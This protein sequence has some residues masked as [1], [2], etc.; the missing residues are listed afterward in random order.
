MPWQ[1]PLPESWLGQLVGGALGAY[2]ISQ[3]A[4][5][6][7]SDLATQQAQQQDIASNIAARSAQQKYQSTQQAME[8][9]ESGFT[10]NPDGTV[11]QEQGPPLPKPPKNANPDQLATFWQ[12]IASDMSR[13]EWQRAQAQQSATGWGNL[14]YKASQTAV[15]QAKVPDIQ[16]HTNYLNS[17]YQRALGVLQQKDRDRM[18]QIRSQEQA[19]LEKQG[20]S[21]ADAMTRA[22]YVAGQEMQRLVVGDQA[23]AALA[24][25]GQQWRQ[26]DLYYSQAMQNY[27]ASENAARMGASSGFDQAGWEA[28]NPPPQQPASINFSPVMVMPGG[29]APQQPQ[30]A[31]G[32]GGLPQ[33]PQGW[34]WTQQ[35]DGRIG[36][37]DAQGNFRPY[38]GAGGSA[39]SAAPRPTGLPVRQVSAPPRVAAPPSR[40]AI[41]KADQAEYDFMVKSYRAQ[42]KSPYEAD[43]QARQTLRLPQVPQQ[44]VAG[45]FGNF[46]RNAFQEHGKAPAAPPA[47]S[48]AAAMAAIQQMKKRYNLSDQQVQQ[49]QPD[50]WSAAHG[51]A[52]TAVP[53]YP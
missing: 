52:A 8:A 36:I 3:Q 13:P 48:R 39:A 37:V 27:R 17:S 40:Y 25:Y 15:N 35:P 21:A 30:P 51:T 31:P 7:K 24:Q 38:T 19:A 11:A 5:Q 43:Q 49:A 28:Q 46:V 26:Q 22:Q 2:N 45:L 4:R 1:M 9:A 16:A 29:A 50:L 23:K 18:E 32:G 44:S 41:P 20:M 12:G 10:I 53:G 6:Q 14:G 33:A 47:M 42:G 34:T